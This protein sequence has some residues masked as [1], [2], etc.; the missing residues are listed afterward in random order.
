MK[1]IVAGFDAFDPKFFEKLHAEGKTPHLSKLV[2]AGGYARFA[3]SNPPQSEV[4]WTSIATG[5]NPG[6][7]GIFDFVHRNPANYGL[8]VS[9]L[10]TQSGIAGKQFVPPHRAQTL[11]DAAAEDGYPATSLW[12]PA[13]FP[14]RL[15]S[16]VRT[17]PGLGAPDIFGRLGVGIVYSVEAIT[18]QKD[19]KTAQARLARKSPGVFTGEISGP[20]KG[21]RAGGQPAIMPFEL[22]I[23]SDRQARLLIGKQAFALTPGQWSEMI[24][25]GFRV[26]FGLSVKVVTRAIWTRAGDAPVLYFLPLQLHPASSPWPYATPKGWVKKLW[27]DPGPFL[28]SGWPQDTTALEEGFISDEQFM[29]LCRLIFA[30][31]QRIFFRLI[32]E[33]REGV[34][35]CVFDSL[36]RIQHMFWQDRPDLIEG[37]YLQLDGLVGKIQEKLHTQARSNPARLLIVSDHG[38][39]NFDFKVHLNR[40]L[41]ERGYLTLA[42]GAGE[43]S[44]SAADWSKSQA[45]AIGLNSLYLNLAGR[46]GQGIVAPDQCEALTEKL[47]AELLDWRGPDG[48]QVVQQA[49]PNQQAFSG[50]LASYGPDLV[51]GYRP[52]YRAS[53]ETGLGQWGEEVIEPNRDH[54]RGDH[55]IDP[56]AVPGVLFASTGLR[57]VPQ[58]S[59]AD[60][61]ALA[62]GKALT[63]GQVAPPPVSAE[64]QEALEERLKGLGYL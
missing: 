27:Q 18:A 58:P 20:A 21:P 8:F 41:L 49:A 26:G 9:L 17:I 64:D 19:L 7:H 62:I 45:Y 55:C 43:A 36:D 57:D 23:Q 34:L 29:A 28:T 13:T 6:G 44:L 48:Q 63:P 50:P 60:F 32:D 10:P 5:Q 22:Q 54:W 42:E 14:A 47:R 31:R 59:Y 4:S 38:F 51:V 52:G 40:W 33:F 39:T 37:W 24:E 12:W 16:P 1:T 2:Q 61:P 53:S 30:E 56:Q 11:F 35:A 25:I 46:E 3:V 15:Q